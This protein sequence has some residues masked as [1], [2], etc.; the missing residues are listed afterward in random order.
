MRLLKA[1]LKGFT[2]F[3]YSGVKKLT[4]DY[5]SD[6]QVILGSN[7]SGKSSYLRAL[8]P[9]PLSRSMFKER[10]VGYRELVIEHKGDV[11]KLIS[12]YSNKTSPHAF[13]KNDTTNLN[14]GGTTNV[15]IEL[16]ETHLGLSKEREKLL[17]GEISFC[18]MSPGQLKPFLMKICPLDLDWILDKQKRAS[19]NLR[20]IKSE[21]TYLTAR[22]TQLLSEMYDE[23]KLKE[24]VST[25]DNY[26]VDITKLVEQKS[27]LNTTIE[28]LRVKISELEDAAKKIC[29][30][31]M[32]VLYKEL[33]QAKEGYRLKSLSELLKLSEDIDPKDYTKIEYKRD[34]TRDGI[35]KIVDKIN[36]IDSS[37]AKS[38][39]EI[40]EALT[41]QIT[42]DNNRV[43]ELSDKIISDSLSEADILDI[44][45]VSGDLKECLTYI[46]T[47]NGGKRIW[48]RKHLRFKELL[49][50]RICSKVDS[51]TTR[52]NFLYQ[53]IDSITREINTGWTPDISPC[54]KNKCPLY[55]LS[56]TTRNERIYTMEEYKKQTIALNRYI[57][58][59]QSYIEERK[60]DLTF[61]S[62]V[63]LGLE[64]LRDLSVKECTA[65]LRFIRRSDLLDILARNPYRLYSDIEDYVRH[66]EYTNEYNALR[67]RIDEN[68]HRLETI[69]KVSA[70]YKKYLIKDKSDLEKELHKSKTEYKEL[71]ELY[72]SI[73]ERKLYTSYKERVDHLQKMIAGL[74]ESY[75]KIRKERD[76]RSDIEDKISDIETNLV[77][78]MSELTQLEIE[79]SSQ[80]KIHSRYNEEVKSRKDSL[81]KKFTDLTDLEYALLELSKLYI[82]R[83]LLSLVDQ[84]NK[85]IA[86]VWNQPLE[87]TLVDNGK[88]YKFQV[89]YKGDM[90]DNIN[91]CSSGQK[92]I[93]DLCVCLALRSP[94]ASLD[95]VG[96]RGYPLALDETGRT[97]DEAHKR[98]LIDLFTIITEEGLV[99]QIL[100]TSH[101][102]VIHGA[103]TNVQTLVLNGDNIALPANYNQDIK[104]KYA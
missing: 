59:Y 17:F 51:Y 24:L 79:L 69:G 72:Q 10:T 97:F 70:S 57:N 84:V 23:T 58:R 63:E 100:L 66:S 54:A 81:D 86:V 99:S 65:L 43:K 68:K 20:N 31:P 18:D 77:I 52:I 7:S 82:H 48:S 56:V 21:L 83:W 28:H 35:E 104:I 93:I 5:N 102:S 62:S 32:D 36:D 42:S 74:T 16:I 15:Q 13:I 39:D 4:V 2:P 22:E 40:V 29:D 94:V 78:K 53:E 60:S 95:G 101:H 44:K 19:S 14:D 96:M 49:H 61:R 55:V 91:L 3:K 12:D 85:F 33:E 30:T 75:N 90:I 76:K 38:D 6:L 46:S 45:R 34:T 64:R 88:E 50:A 27:S 80:D 41:L 73:E 37:L 98:N 71:E 47:V 25:K 67:T 26:H 87:L 11:Y 92:D 9:Y 89:K 1:V 8:T 103:L